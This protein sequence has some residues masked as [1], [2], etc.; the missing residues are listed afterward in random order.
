ML[1]MVLNV[2]GCLLPTWQITPRNWRM[3]SSAYFPTPIASLRRID[4]LMFF[5][6]FHPTSIYTPEILNTNRKDDGLEHLFLA[7]K[8]G[9]IY[10]FF[11]YIYV[12]FQVGGNLKGGEKT[13]GTQD[14]HILNLFK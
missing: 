13:A 14:F 9:Y 3:V 12:Q 5:H 10:I 2:A 8:N 7:S 6:E 11:G 1:G 4:S